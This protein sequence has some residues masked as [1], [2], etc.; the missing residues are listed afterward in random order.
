[1]SQTE[2]WILVCIV[3]VSIG[4][5]F[6]LFF[7]LIGKSRSLTYFRPEYEELK[8]V[9]ASWFDPGTVQIRWLKWWKDFY[10]GQIISGRRY[11]V[12]VTLELKTQFSQGYMVFNTKNVWDAFVEYPVLAEMRVY[13]K[14]THLGPVAS[15]QPNFEQTVQVDARQ[16]AQ[17][18]KALE[19]GFLSLAHDREFLEVL[20]MTAQSFLKERPAW[21]R[22][23][24]GILYRRRANNLPA[25]TAHPQA[26]IAFENHFKLVETTNRYDEKTT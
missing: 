1:M 17:V 3:F 18:S 15:D 7:I 26:A 25:L 8:P 11:G 23:R 13:I 21:T 9:I 19:K 2:S 22:R 12:P 16:G 5:L 24:A 10:N 6:C 14:S 20:F 4:V